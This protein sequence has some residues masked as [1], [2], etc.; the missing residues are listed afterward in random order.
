M[1][2]TMRLVGKWTG[3]RLDAQLKITSQLKYG[4]DWNLP[5]QAFMAIK[6]STIPSGTIT[7]VDATAAKAMPGVI[8]VLTTDDVKNDPVL[9]KIKYSEVYLLP[10]DKVRVSGEEVACVVAEDP[11]IA[12]EA[13]QAIKVTYQASSFVLGVVD[14]VKTTAPQVFDGTPNMIPSTTYKFGDADTAMNTQGA[15]ILT[16]TYESN[17]VQVNPIAAFAGTAWVDLAG[18]VEMWCNTQDTKGFSRDIAKALGIA[19][20]RVRVYNI[21]CDG[22]YGDK[23]NLH[24]SQLLAA[25][26]SQRTGRPVHWRMTCEHQLIMGHHRPRDVFNVSTAY[27]SDGTVVA[28]KGEILNNASP[29]GRGIGGFPGGPGSCAYFYA[30]YKFPNFTMVGTDIYANT[31]ATG[32]YRLPAGPHPSWAF[33]THLDKIANKLGM[34]PVDLMKKNNMY[35]SGDTDQLT[36]NRII[37]CGQPDVMNKVLQMS[38]F[39]TKWKKAPAAGTKLTGVVHGIGISNAA[40]GNGATPSN[41]S[42]VI[43]MQ[44]DGSLNI[45]ID[46]N[47][48]GEG[49]REQMAL[50]GAEAMGLPFNYVTV[51]NYDSD[52]GTDSGGTVGSTQTKGAGN[53]I[54][55]ACIDAKNQMLA[56]AATSLSTTV[57]KLTYALDGSMKIFLTADP[58][59]SVTFA[60]LCGEPAIIGLGRMVVPTKST[61]RVYNTCAAEV[62]VDTDTGLVKVTDLYIAQDVGRVIFT[63]GITGQVQGAVIEAMGQALQE[64]MWPDPVTGKQL[65]I[66]QLDHKM[67]LVTQVPNIQV[68]FIENVEQAPDSYNFGAKGMAEPP[69]APVIPAIAN[70]VA[71]AIGAYIDQLP[72]TPEKVLKALGKA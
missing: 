16:A 37:S 62:D 13:C 64:E 3:R 26:M 30:I 7:A 21:C 29:V 15:Q 5:N 19:A 65:G 4:N 61:G 8:A 58:T 50:I 38:N 49:R 11:Y 6:L 60:S 67:P 28:L 59:K 24:R 52:C 57:D 63:A 1:S 12:A 48:I 9:S 23:G 33:S 46:S 32:A 41:R 27:L 35:V 70:A 10:W 45:H 69:M 72:L 51:N 71:N 44:S 14:A 34:N 68:A 18:R 25:I 56:K 54:G 31:P 47:D 17:H 42:G 43:I 2:S 39:Q 53:A 22:G 55:L 36:G 40:A 20:S 66:C